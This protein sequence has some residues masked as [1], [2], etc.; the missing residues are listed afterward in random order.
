LELEISKSKRTIDPKTQKETDLVKIIKKEM[1]LFENGG[2]R[3]H[4]LE[5]AFKYL[6]SI[7]PTSIE[8]ERAFSAAAYIGNKLR[9]RLGDGTLDALLLLRSYFQHK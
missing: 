6:M 8:S 4:H 7:P 1:N 2:T 9:S 5:L 3:G